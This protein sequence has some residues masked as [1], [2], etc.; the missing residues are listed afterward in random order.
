MGIEPTTSHVYSHTLVPLRHDRYLVW[1]SFKIKENNLF[2][3][4]E[5]SKYGNDH[6][7]IDTTFLNMFKTIECLIQYF[8]KCDLMLR[9]IQALVTLI[10]K[11][12]LIHNKYY[13]NKMILNFLMHPK[14]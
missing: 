12:N 4:N 3:I 6:P 8:F 10:Y 7:K 1:W 2:F 13:T 14:G 9:G 11:F 5:H